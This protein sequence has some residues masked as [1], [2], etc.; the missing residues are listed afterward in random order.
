MEVNV[1]DR[2]VIIVSV[3]DA[4]AVMSVDVEVDDVL[5]PVSCFQMCNYDCR[6]VE[7]AEA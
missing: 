2:G 7:Y 5:H 1:E 4:V 3:H 6:I